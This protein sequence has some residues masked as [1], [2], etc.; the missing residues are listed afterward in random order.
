MAKKGSS[1][2]LK[3]QVEN[4]TDHNILLPART[5]RTAFGSLALGRSI[6]PM[7]MNF[8]N[9]QSAGPGSSATKW[10]N[11][12]LANVKTC[13]VTEGVLQKMDLEHLSPD[14]RKEVE[15]M[16]KDEISSFS[17]DDQVKSS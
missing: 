7:S 6:I 8:G 12:N 1:S 13:Q 11:E 9:S 10:R 2:V 17:K 15:A 16:L 4:E 14:E 3:L 5:A